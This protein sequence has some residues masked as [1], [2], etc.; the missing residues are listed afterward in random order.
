MMEGSYRVVLA[1]L[2]FA[3]RNIRSLK[4]R[5][6]RIGSGRESS[7]HNQNAEEQYPDEAADDDRR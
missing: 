7:N 5:R 6:C 1:K 4:R 2:R 3:E